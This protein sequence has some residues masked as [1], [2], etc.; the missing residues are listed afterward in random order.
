M[1][2]WSKKSKFNSFNSWKG[3]LYAKWYEA[4]AAGKFLPP[5]EASIDP[6]HSCNLNCKH[7]NAHRLMTHQKMPDDHFINL[8][9]FLGKWGVKAVCIAGGGEP[10]LHPKLHEAIVEARISGMEASII[11]N[12]V[13]L[14]GKLLDTVPLCRWVGVSV[15]AATQETFLKL[16]GVDKFQTVIGNILRATKNSGACDIG[17][18]FLISSLNQGEIYDACKLAKELGVHDFH[19]RPMD[20][21]HQGMGEELDGNLSD[22]NVD[23]INDQMEQCHELESEDFRVFTVTHK[24]N[25]DFTPR[26][27]FSQCFAAP[28]LIQLCADGKTYFCVD[29]RQQKEFELGTHY[30]NPENILNFWGSPRHVDMVLR[31]HI[32]ERCTTRCT[33]GAYCEQCEQ[34]VINDNDPMCWRFT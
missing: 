3:L 9:H 11:T 23:L 14:R 19:A 5:I 32:P 28:L 26:K 8:V 18:K 17:F 33:F 7:C 13:L 34:L 1:T 20:F 27:N 10:T 16:K 25:P 2:E 6:I 12:G 4:I 15:D 29:Q 30:P 22:I 21:H 31:D 24:F